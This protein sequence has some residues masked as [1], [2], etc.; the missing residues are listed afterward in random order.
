[1]KRRKGKDF[2]EINNQKTQYNGTG[3]TLKDNFDSAK[4]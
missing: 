1:L 3:Q 4:G 2:K